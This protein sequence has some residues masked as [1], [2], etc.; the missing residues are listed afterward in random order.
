[1]KMTCSWVKAL[2]MIFLIAWILVGQA[3][4]SWAQDNTQIPVDTLV[5]ENNLPGVAAQ[6]VQSGYFEVPADRAA[7]II[8]ETIANS[9]Q[10]N[11]QV[12]ISTDSPDLFSKVDHT[13]H[14]E[15]SEALA[16]LM[17]TQPERVTTQEKQTAMKK[18]WNYTKDSVRMDPIGMMI[19]TVTVG[20]DVWMW[21]HASQ[22]SSMTIGGQVLT[23]LV[24]NLALALRKNTWAELNTRFADGI[25]APIIRSVGFKNLTSARAEIMVKMISNFTLV[26]SIQAMR[27]GIIIGGGSGHVL[28]GN[29]NYSLTE[30]AL[31]SGVTAFLVAA[32][33]SFNNFGW[34]NWID[35]I[36]KSK[37]INLSAESFM[38]AT[39]RE[40]SSMIAKFLAYRFYET[41]SLIAGTFI[42][43][44]ALMSPSVY[45]YSSWIWVA[46]HGTLGLAA[47]LGDRV[48][49]KLLLA[50]G[51]GTTQVSRSFSEGV[52]S[53]KKLFGSSAIKC[54]SVFAN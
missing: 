27:L 38:R 32:A 1:M 50:A 25:I 5:I 29:S 37:A 7:T 49:I 8:Q 39:V 3:S 48:T 15:R 28:M 45:G 36:A 31:K 24:V 53:F 4:L 11:T 35:K 23:S 9:K 54:E 51:K 2:K 17:E 40:R 33:F 14:T 46:A 18:L 26:M 16:V 6:R 43:S 52:V 22:Y 20:A 10:S 12:V 30:V 44:A 19:T 41:R 42:T 13:I 47:Y 34:E 21:V